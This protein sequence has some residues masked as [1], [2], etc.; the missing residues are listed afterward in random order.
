MDP[1]VPDGVVVSLQGVHHVKDLLGHLEN[2]RGRRGM[3]GEGFM[4]KEGEREEEAEGGRRKEGWTNLQEGEGEGRKD[5][6][7]GG[8][9]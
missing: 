7:R 4:R 8:L 6:Q 1:V 2:G 5:K 9:G 3:D